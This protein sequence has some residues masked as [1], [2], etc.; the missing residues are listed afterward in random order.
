MKRLILSNLICIVVTVWA[1]TTASAQYNWRS[2]G[3]D[4]LGSKTR[5]LAFTANGQLLAGSEGG[6]L[7]ASQDK[8]LSWQRVEGYTGNPNIT[9]I[10]VDGDRILVGTGAVSF[11]IS[12]YAAILGSIYDFSAAPEGFI[13]STVLPGAWVYVS[14]DNGGSWSITNATILAQPLKV[15]SVLQDCL[16]RVFTCPRIMEPA[17]LIQMQLPKHLLGQVP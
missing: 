7:W 13:G 17:G 8:G 6:G 9:S 2:L 10:A 5:T 14:T 12:P 16:E 1:I 11:S 15:L 4:N 3:P